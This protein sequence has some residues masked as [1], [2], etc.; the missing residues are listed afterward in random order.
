MEPEG[1]IP[2]SKQP[3][4]GPYPEPDE[5]NS[6][7]LRFILILSFLLI[8]GL[9]SVLFLSGFPTEIV[10]AFFIVPIWTTYTAYDILL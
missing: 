5:S 4:P 1:S 2:Y 10:C 9:P 6:H 8:L 7:P 3:N